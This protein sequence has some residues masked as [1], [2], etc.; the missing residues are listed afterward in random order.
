M[1]HRFLYLIR[2]KGIGRKEKKNGEKSGFRA[3]PVIP[4]VGILTARRE[5]PKVGLA[6]GVKS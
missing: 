4:K 6:I 3:K 1:P 5:P 2:N